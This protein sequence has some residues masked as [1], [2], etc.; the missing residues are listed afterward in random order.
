[1]TCACPT[2]TARV[3]LVPCSVEYLGSGTPTI[4]TKVHEQAEDHITKFRHCILA[5]VDAAIEVGMNVFKCG[6]YFE[7]PTVL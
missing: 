2:I 6:W 3:V 4:V 5:Q 7:S 1:M